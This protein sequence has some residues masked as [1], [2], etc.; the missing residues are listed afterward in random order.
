MKSVAEEIGCILLVPT[1]EMPKNSD[2]MYTHAL[3]RD[4]LLNN[5]GTLARIDLQ[6]INIID[7]AKE[8]CLKKGITILCPTM[9]LLERK[10]EKSSYW[11]WRKICKSG[12]KNP[13]KFMKCKAAPL[14]NSSHMMA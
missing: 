13:N 5:T 12:G 8:L 6:L 14:L 1:F 11:C 7:D 9:T 10:I 2:L 3:D 4:T